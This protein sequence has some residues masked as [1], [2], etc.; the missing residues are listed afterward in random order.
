MH[1]PSTSSSSSSSCRLFSKWIGDSRR[2]KRLLGF[3]SCITEHRNEWWGGNHRQV[4]HKTW[5]ILSRPPPHHP[6]S[7]T[8]EWWWWRCSFF[9]P[10]LQRSADRLFDSS[11]L[12]FPFEEINSII[13]E[14]TSSSPWFLTSLS[15]H[16]ADYRPND[17]S[18]I[19]YRINECL[20]HRWWCR[21]LIR[22]DEVTKR[23]FRMEQKE[24]NTW[25]GDSFFSGV[26]Q[27]V[28]RIL[29][30]FNI[31]S[32]IRWNSPFCKSF[33]TINDVERFQESKRWGFFKKDIS[34][35]GRTWFRSSHQLF[36]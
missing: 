26:I 5:I 35:D 14:F 28:K 32:C 36:T 18:D 34:S 21:H 23:F 3:L 7:S 19:R 4:W 22:R 2:A 10:W 1:A 33:K 15:Y 31:M 12:S 17:K 30:R 13:I 6:P 16:F 25:D 29:N 8:S 24:R 27:F 9:C 11:S 20:H